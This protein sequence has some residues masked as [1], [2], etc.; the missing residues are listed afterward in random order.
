MQVTEVSISLYDSAKIKGFADVVLDDE[1]V[2]R[3]IVIVSY[4][5]KDAN[6]SK[7]RIELPNKKRK[8][9]N[10]QDIVHPIKKELF[11][12]IVKEVLTS[13]DEAVKQ[14]VQ[15]PEQQPSAQSA[16]QSVA[17]APE[18]RDTSSV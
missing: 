13:Y 16:P 8:N 6:K 17:V 1:L 4:F 5:N 10:T 14:E 7:L 15:K 18:M 11:N 12:N 9:G 3:G 2:I